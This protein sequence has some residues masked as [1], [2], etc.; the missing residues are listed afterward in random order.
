MEQSEL[1]GRQPFESF[2]QTL[3]SH[4]TVFSA[5]LNLSKTKEIKSLKR[6]DGEKGEQGRKQTKDSLTR[7]F[8]I[9][10][11]VETLYGVP[12][13]NIENASNKNPFLVWR[14]GKK[15]SWTEVKHIP[16]ALKEERDKRLTK[17]SHFHCN[18]LTC[19]KRQPKERGQTLIAADALMK[20]ESMSA[21]WPLFAP[22]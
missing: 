2:L 6:R 1:N 10:V 17:K 16:V 3:F 18:S 19:S 22:S 11:T 8:G 12:P 13:L 5:S 15:R 21:L 4:I 9:N 7:L 14:G 20:G